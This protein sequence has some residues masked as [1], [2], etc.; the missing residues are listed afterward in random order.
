M[1]ILS[2]A[3]VLATG[4]SLLALTAKAQNTN[5]P[6]PA[7]SATPEPS[8][9]I[10]PETP[11]KKAILQEASHL[12]KMEP[13]KGWVTSPPFED[14]VHADPSSGYITIE[15]FLDEELSPATPIR[16]TQDLPTDTQ[17]YEFACQMA[18]KLVQRAVKFN[19]ENKIPIDDDIIVDIDVV[20]E[21]KVGGLPSGVQNGSKNLAEAKYLI[22]KY[23]I[24]IMEP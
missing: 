12:L 20:Q 23:K 24:V 1:K 10:R 15:C 18:K 22:K 13:N 17:I 5:A 19:Q 2:L 21:T 4:C 9:T 3:L 6:S 7:V 14:R 8:A 16:D 11:F